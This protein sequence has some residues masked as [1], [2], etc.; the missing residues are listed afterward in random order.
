VPRR[1]PH[2]PAGD[3]APAAHATRAAFERGRAR[4]AHLLCAG[5]R[6][7]RITWRQL[8]D[9]PERSIA[10]LAAALAQV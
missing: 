1:A 10:Q 3:P 5:D 4:D 2:R 6:V 8:H 7:L 9:A